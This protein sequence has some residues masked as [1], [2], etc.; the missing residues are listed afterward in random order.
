MVQTTIRIQKQLKEKLSL[1]A[2]QKGYSLKDL[3]IIILDD[4]VQSAIALK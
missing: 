2:Q 4:H 1:Y 3:I